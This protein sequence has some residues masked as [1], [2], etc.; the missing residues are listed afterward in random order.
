MT[1]RKPTPTERREDAG[2]SEP[3]ARL[4]AIINTVVDGIITIDASGLIESLNPAAERIFGYKAKELIGK[5]VSVLMPA[6]WSRQH[7]AYIQRYLKTGQARIVGIGRE[8][9]GRRKN[10]TVFPMDLAVSELRLG[11]RILFTGIVRDITER[12]R[13]EE[14][15]AQVS[16]QERRRLGQELHDGL[17]QHLTGVTL[18]TKALQ[19]RLA[20]DQHPAHTDA[21]ELAA[22]LGRILADMRRHAH[23]L[24]PVELER[25]GLVAALEELAL[26]HRQLFGIDC[27]LTVT[28][29]VPEI[30]MQAAL[31]LFRIAQEAMH[32]AVRHGEAKQICIRIDRSSSMLHM[33]VEDDGRGIR[34]RKSMPGMGIT[35][36]RRRASVL[37]ASLD[38]RKG[39]LRGT[40]VRLVWQ[41]GP[42]IRRGS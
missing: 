27:R 3:A 25:R 28:G 10:G 24:Y 19:S 37:G 4:S 41:P 33:E 30:E 2:D 32:N 13:D 31:H 38:I 34:L 22:M 18:L 29:T 40:V 14:A 20:R 11:D 42:A 6:P 7:D 12:K 23:G 16:E 26:T 36:M 9:Q 15:I 8:V 35:I 39:K 1:R 5:N 17:G 21:G